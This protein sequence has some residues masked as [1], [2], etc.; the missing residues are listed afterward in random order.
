MALP[1]PTRTV[2]EPLERKPTLPDRD[3]NAPDSTAHGRPY[4]LL[5]P[6]EPRRPCPFS[7]ARIE[8]TPPNQSS[9]QRGPARQR[10]AATAHSR[11]WGVADVRRHPGGAKSWTSAVLAARQRLLVVHPVACASSL[12]IFKENQIERQPPYARWRARESS[13]QAQKRGTPR[14]AS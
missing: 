11:L 1:W 10:V 7:C 8:R 4:K 12:T 6:N 5:C 3:T 14:R 13:S 2:G 9:A